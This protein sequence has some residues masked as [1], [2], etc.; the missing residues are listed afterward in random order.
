[1]GGGRTYNWKE[2]RKNLG[3]ACGKQMR[4]PRRRLT[5]TAMK[6]RAT[7][8]DCPIRQIR[9]GVRGEEAAL[10]W[11]ASPRSSQETPQTCAACA[12]AATRS[13]A[14]HKYPSQVAQSV[15]A[16]RRF[17]MLFELDAEI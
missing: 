11:G 3:R 7:G 2:S 17:T 12:V 14:M 15:C 16:R 13:T 4:E 6:L 9:Q 8:A 1:M 10:A 5:R